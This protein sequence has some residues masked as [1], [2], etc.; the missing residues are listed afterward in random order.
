MN[1]AGDCQKSGPNIGNCFCKLNV[2]GRTCDTCKDGYFNISSDNV[3]GCKGWCQLDI[4]MCPLGGS[5]SNLSDI[6]KN[7][8]SVTK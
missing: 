8:F 7:N 1:D 6:F 4:H 2:A 5:I 3:D